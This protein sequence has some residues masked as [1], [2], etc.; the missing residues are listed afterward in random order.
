MT[1]LLCGLKILFSS[2]FCSLIVNTKQGI[3]EGMKT[4]PTSI[5]SWTNWQEQKKYAKK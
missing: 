2:S 5:E 4:G 3:V 1:A